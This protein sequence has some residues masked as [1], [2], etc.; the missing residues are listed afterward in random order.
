[1]NMRLVSLI[2]RNVTRHMIVVQSRKVGIES[3][4][5]MSAVAFERL[6]ANII[7]LL[8]AID[9]NSKIITAKHSTM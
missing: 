4:I 7:L 1:M 8:K 5:N 2:Y 6:S 9:T 3:L